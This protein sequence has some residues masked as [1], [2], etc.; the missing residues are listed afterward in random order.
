MA[1][2]N[3][4]F[5]KK[6]YKSECKVSGKKIIKTVLSSP[7]HTPAAVPRS[8]DIFPLKQCGLKKYGQ[9]VYSYFSKT[10]LVFLKGKP[11]FG[12]YIQEKSFVT[13]VI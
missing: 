3:L 8:G 11:V 4:C 5:A 12:I 9:I 7:T 13:E 10:I 6:K 1:Q 2:S